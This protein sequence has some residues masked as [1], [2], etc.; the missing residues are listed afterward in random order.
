M[1]KQR[2]GISPCSPV[3]LNDGPLYFIGVEGVGMGQAG[4]GQLG[5]LP[6]GEGITAPGGSVRYR[7][8]FLGGQ[9]ALPRVN[10]EGDSRGSYLNSLA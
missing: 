8:C 4:E 9:V 3:Y 7:G 5:S 6:D 10:K 1:T 2:P